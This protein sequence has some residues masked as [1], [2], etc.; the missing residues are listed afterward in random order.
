[1]TIIINPNKKPPRSRAAANKAWLEKVNLRIAKRLEK[2][3][4][5]KRPKAKVE[6][7]LDALSP[8]LLEKMGIADINNTPNSDKQI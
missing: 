8:E 5:R 3:A 4:N 1:M 6:Y 7:T 2:E